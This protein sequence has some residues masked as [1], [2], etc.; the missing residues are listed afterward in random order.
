MDVFHA[1]SIAIG[2]GYLG[3][4]KFMMEESGA[5][6]GE[7]FENGSSYGYEWPLVCAI[8]HGKRDIVDYLYERKRYQDKSLV[9]AFCA[10]AQAGSL[11]LVK[12]LNGSRDFGPSALNDAFASAAEGGQLEMMTH[13]QSHQKFDQTAI[14]KALEATAGRGQLEAVKYLSKLKDTR[15]RLLSWINPLNALAAAT[16]LKYCST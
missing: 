1:M 15:C 10:A 16:V 13:L 12:M 8:K 3:I 14:D 4:V 5:E 11:E 7:Y 6:L 2:S 9:A